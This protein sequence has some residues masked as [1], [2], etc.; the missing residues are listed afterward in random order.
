MKAVVLLSGGLDSA[1][2]LAWAAS[3]CEK[4][5]A[6]TFNYGQRHAAR[7]IDAARAL[8]KQYGATWISKRLPFMREFGSTLLYMP[9]NDVPMA[10]LSGADTIVD[11]RNGIFIAIATGYAST[12]QADWVYLGSHGGDRDVYPDCRPA[13]T[14]HMDRA[15]Q[16]GTVSGVRVAA[17]FDLWPKSEVVELGRTLGVRFEDTWSCYEGGVEPCEQCGACVGREQALARVP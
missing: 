7:E 4:V 3:R 8:A 9:R 13:F 1:V 17:P 6:L 11:F 14:D 2:L 5:Y 15:A 10:A 16:A 12:Y